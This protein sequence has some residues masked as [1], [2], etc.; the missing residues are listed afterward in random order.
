M[1]KRAE[2]YKRKVTFFKSL[3]ATLAGISGI[4]GEGPKNSVS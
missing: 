1:Q 3:F 2:G 4:A